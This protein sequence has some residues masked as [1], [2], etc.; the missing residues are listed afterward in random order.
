MDSEE[1]KVHAWSTGESLMIQV[2]LELI[3]KKYKITKY[4]SM[5]RW[6]SKE[7]INNQNKILKL[8][9]SMIKLAIKENKYD[10]VE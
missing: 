1:K 10:W 4:L 5:A 7:I 9:D 6:L 8:V 3:G 2:P